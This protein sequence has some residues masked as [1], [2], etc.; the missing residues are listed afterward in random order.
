VDDGSLRRTWGTAHGVFNVLSGAWPLV[1]VR[2]FE[3]VTGPKHDRWLEYTVGGLLVI[4]GSTQISAARRDDSATSRQLGLGVPAVLTAID[5][6]F[7]A[8]KRIR[9]IYL[10]DAA[11]EIS[12]VAGWMFVLWRDSTKMAPGS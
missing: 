12:L 9:P 5:L 3:A 6:V 4:A 2:S 7:V 8:R 1:H 11:M 10:V